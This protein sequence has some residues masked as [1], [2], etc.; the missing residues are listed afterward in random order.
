MFLI[1]HSVILTSYPST[2]TKHM[3]FVPPGKW[4]SQ[5]RCDT[6]TLV[7]PGAYCNRINNNLPMA[8]VSAEVVFFSH[9]KPDLPFY[10]WAITPEIKKSRGR[11]K[12]SKNKPKAKLLPWALPE[13]FAVSAKPNAAM[14][15]PKSP[16]SKKLVGCSVLF[17]WPKLGWCPGVI[18]N[19]NEDESNTIGEDMVNFEIYYKI[20]DNL[21]RHC[22]DIEQCIPNGPAGSWVLLEQ[23]RVPAVDEMVTTDVVIDI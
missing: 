14:L 9:K 6:G 4:A 8:H 17:H 23:T 18:R 13:G 5:P 2:Y 22:L 20:D 21:S 1:I 19:A 7:V 11:P 10:T 12:G 15:E 16:E 3:S